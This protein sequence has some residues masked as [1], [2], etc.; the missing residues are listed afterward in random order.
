MLACSGFDHGHLFVT[1][2]IKTRG[3]SFFGRSAAPAFQGGGQAEKHRRILRRW[4]EAERLGIA[5]GYEGRRPQFGSFHLLEPNTLG[6]IRETNRLWTLGPR[7]RDRNYHTVGVAMTLKLLSWAIC[8][9]LLVTSPAFGE[10]RATISPEL[11]SLFE[12]LDE[13]GRD[14]VARGKFVSLTL[15]SEREPRQ[16]PDPVWL[17]EKNDASIVVLA[18][19][20]LPWRYSKTGTTTLPDS[21]QPREVVLKSIKEADFEAACKQLA[22]PPQDEEPTRRLGAAGPSRRLL[23][24]HAAWK[25][26]LSK[27]VEPILHGEP[28]YKQGF[29]E[30]QKATLEDFAWLHFLRGV[31]LL[32]FA[33][34]RE[35]LPQLKLSITLAPESEIAA[36]AKDLV[37]RLESIVAQEQQPQAKPDYSKLSIEQLAEAYIAQIKNLHSPQFSQPGFIEP[38]SGAV[39]GQS[40]LLA[41]TMLLKQMGD[42][43]V[44][45]LIKA[46]DDDSPTRTVYHWRDF[47]RNRV[48]WTVSD[49]AWHILR[50][51]TGKELGYRRR[52]GRPS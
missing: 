47:A 41:P 10:V 6:R 39:V 7:R 35:V 48:V 21:W 18:A 25:K 22:A 43:A 27:Y 4:A 30:F 46:L 12:R 26:G 13:L 38:Y 51:I 2:L 28:A 20:L 49:F 24:A 29:A 52:V 5:I 40:A 3:P 15:E 8:C 23:A 31:N 34:R 44:P 45:A 32:M 42:K 16:L 11:K 9:G 1:L 17:I 37:K 14:R 33:D 36:Q 19:D 50:D